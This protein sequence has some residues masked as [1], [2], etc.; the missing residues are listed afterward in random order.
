MPSL[1]RRALGGGKSQAVVLDDFATK[2]AA[3]CRIDRLLVANLPILGGPLSWP[4]AVPACIIKWRDLDHAD[5]GLCL[6]PVSAGFIAW[7]Q[8][9][10]KGC[11][12]W[13]DPL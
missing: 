9:S 10:R 4:P 13:G 8:R 11:S 3:S 1:K 6:L 7:P 5:F 12:T 2:R